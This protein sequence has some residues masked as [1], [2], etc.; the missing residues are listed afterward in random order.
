MRGTDLQR[1]HVVPCWPLRSAPNALHLL[2]ESWRVVHQPWPLEFRSF[3]RVK[4]VTDV[5]GVL[6]NFNFD[7]HGISP[8]PGERVD[9]GDSITLPTEDTFRIATF[10]GRCSDTFLA[11]VN[12]EIIRRAGLSSL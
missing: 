11:S 1:R 9:G 2:L 4:D 6:M 3:R 10:R 8:A 7:P 5:V 12:G